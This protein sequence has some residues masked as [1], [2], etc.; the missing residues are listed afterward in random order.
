MRLGHP[1]LVALLARIAQMNID[2]L[3]SSN[4]IGSNQDNKLPSTPKLECKC[5]RRIS[6]LTVSKT[7]LG[8]SNVRSV[9]C[10][11]FMFIRISFWTLIRAISVL[12]IV[13]D[14]IIE[15]VGT[16]RPLTDV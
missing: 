10:C 9:T 4:Y 3:R 13:S 12:S 16:Y 8:L 14:K 2:M 15:T 1:E 6:D 11:L 7:A 5:E